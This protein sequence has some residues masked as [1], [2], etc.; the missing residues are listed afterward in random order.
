MIDELA[1]PSPAAVLVTEELDINV[2]LLNDDAGWRRIVDQERIAHRDDDA[3]GAAIVL[4]SGGAPS[5]L[6]NSLRKGVLAVLSGARPGCRPM[7]PAGT[8][9][10]DALEALGATAAAATRRLGL[11]ASAWELITWLTSGRMLAPDRPDR[12]YPPPASGHCSAR[13]PATR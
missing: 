7:R 10:G 2:G 9:L 3:A 12:L 11:L 4:L 6:E 1:G 8:P 13:A 5:W